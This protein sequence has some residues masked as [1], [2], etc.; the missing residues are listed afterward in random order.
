MQS[1]RASKTKSRKTSKPRPN[2]TAR[3]NEAVDAISVK[4]NE[5]IVSCTEYVKHNKTCYY[6]REQSVK[7]AECLRY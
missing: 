6:D 3:L 2:K 7:C 5:A 1:F 4:E